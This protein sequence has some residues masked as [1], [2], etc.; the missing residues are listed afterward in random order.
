MQLGPE[1]RK[2]WKES[3]VT[4]RPLAGRC[5]RWDTRL[6]RKRTMMSSLHREI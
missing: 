1:A 3:I 6:E 2:G 5:F 4:M